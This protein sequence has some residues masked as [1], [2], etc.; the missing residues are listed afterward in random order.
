MSMFLQS[1]RI[2]KTGFVQQL[3]LK[4]VVNKRAA[5][6]PN[7]L[8]CLQSDRAKYHLLCPPQCLDQHGDTADLQLFVDGLDL[9]AYSS[10]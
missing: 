9:I 2:Q 1:C 8:G 7:L 10:W 4:R 5:N 6:H 3:A